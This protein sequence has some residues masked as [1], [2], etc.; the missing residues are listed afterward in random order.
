MRPTLLERAGRGPRG[1]RL[2]SASDA[3]RDELAAMGVDVEDTRDGQRWHRIEVE[4]GET[5]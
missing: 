3:L 5:A 2:G 1:T 4:R